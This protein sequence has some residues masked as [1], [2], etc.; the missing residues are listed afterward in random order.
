MPRK[1]AIPAA[2]ERSSPPRAAHLINVAGGVLSS[3]RH[4]PGVLQLSIC[5]QHSIVSIVAH[6]LNCCVMDLR[7]IR[8]PPMARETPYLPFTLRLKL[9]QL[10]RL[11]LVIS[12]AEEEDYEDFPL[13]MWTPN[14]RMIYSGSMEPL[15]TTLEQHTIV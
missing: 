6:R 7:H 3:W 14:W 12:D 5:L 11:L 15:R 9:L 2:M 8:P 10:H 4:R 1:I 13:M